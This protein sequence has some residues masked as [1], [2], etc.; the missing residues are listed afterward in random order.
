MSYTLLS[1]DRPAV[2][3]RLPDVSSG[4]WASSGTTSQGSL[5]EL[6][7]H[8]HCNRYP[9]KPV[10]TTKFALIVRPCAGADRTPPGSGGCSSRLAESGALALDQHNLRLMKGKVCSYTFG[11]CLDSLQL[12]EEF[13]G[14][15]HHAQ[16]DDLRSFL[17]GEAV[18]GVWK[19]V[20]GIPL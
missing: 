19:P 10:Y 2:L 14:D 6:Q 16:L 12:P 20:E 8:P 3:K 11:I 9:E 1:K 4:V 15:W 18:R 13:P 5:F 7:G 17:V